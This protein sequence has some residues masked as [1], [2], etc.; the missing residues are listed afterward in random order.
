[1]PHVKP[2]RNVFILGAG[3]SAGAGAPLVRDFLDRS[4]ELFDNP[5]TPLEPY[6]REQFE[7]VFKFKRTMAQAREKVRMDLDDVEKLFGLVEISYRLGEC[8]RETR[9]STVYLIAKTLQ[10]ATSPARRRRSRIGFSIEADALDL[11][12]H[13]DL[14]VKQTGTA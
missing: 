3:F 12:N 7:E 6:E 13:S 2:D 14:F 5:S 1:M 4:R 9:D 10:L 8:R 11:S